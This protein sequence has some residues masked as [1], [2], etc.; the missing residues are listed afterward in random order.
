MSARRKLSPNAG[1]PASKF[2]PETFEA[3]ARDLTTGRTP[4]TRVTV[5]D[6]MVTGLRAVI[7]NTGLVTFHVHYD[8]DDSRPYMKIGEHPGMK[9]DEARS[10]AKTVKA[11]ADKGID[12]QAGLHE[13]LIR[14]LKE[15]GE[16]WKP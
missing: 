13:R 4:L 14:E 7:R 11:L 16:R 15:K 10:I 3:L 2:A 12:V 1:R 6:D 8:F 9:V 5:S